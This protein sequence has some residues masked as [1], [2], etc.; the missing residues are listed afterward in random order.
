MTIT[1]KIIF[2]S[3]KD[4]EKKEIQNYFES[5]L[6]NFIPIKKKIL[7]FVQ[8]SKI[9]PYSNSPSHKYIRKAITEL[10]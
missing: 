6:K 1:K 5:I 10:T 9:K 2:N 8:C 7:L 4:V 3:Y